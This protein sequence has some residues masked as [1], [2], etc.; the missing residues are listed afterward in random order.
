MASSLPRRALNVIGKVKKAQIGASNGPNGGIWLRASDTAERTVMTDFP[1]VTG[2]EFKGAVAHQSHKNPLHE[3]CL[4][5]QLYVGEKRFISGHILSNGSLVYSKE[6]AKG[7]NTSSSHASSSR[8]GHSGSSQS[9]HANVWK[10]TKEMVDQSTWRIL[11]KSKNKWRSVHE[12]PE[13]PSYWYIE[14]GGQ[15]TYF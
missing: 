7:G 10:P 5:V 1:E 4:S 6:K 2:I 15:K 12:D 3:I 9:G 11:D 14:I 13:N 8:S